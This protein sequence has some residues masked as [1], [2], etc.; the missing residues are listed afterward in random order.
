[1]DNIKAKLR[2]ARPF[3]WVIGGISVLAAIYFAIKG[4]YAMATNMGI[5]T[6]L[7]VSIPELLSDDV[8]KSDKPLPTSEEVAEHQ[9]THRTSTLAESINDIREGK[10]S[11][12]A[13]D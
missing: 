9:R 10:A 3:L 13:R 6:A 4:N 12:Q 11:N 7:A 5:I 1:M 8:K 2:T